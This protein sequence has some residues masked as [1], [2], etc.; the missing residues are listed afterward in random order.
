FTGIKAKFERFS[1]Q[2]LDMYQNMP[3]TYFTS[4]IFN[5]FIDRN[6]ILN[7]MQESLIGELPDV[8]KSVVGKF[9]NI[10]EA[11]GKLKA[12]ISDSEL[13]GKLKGIFSK[14][15]EPI[16]E[17]IIK[18]N[19]EVEP[20]FNEAVKIINNYDPKNFQKVV[21][22]LS[23]FNNN[24]I[25]K[26]HELENALKELIEKYKQNPD[27]QEIQKLLVDKYKETQ[28]YLQLLDNYTKELKN[29]DIKDESLRKF[30]SELENRFNINHS[31]LNNF[32]NSHKIDDLTSN[33]KNISGTDLNKLTK[34]QFE[35][36]KKYDPK[37]VQQFQT[38]NDTFIKIKNELAKKHDDIEKS[39]KEALEKYKQNP[40]DQENILSAS[41]TINS[42]TQFL[43]SLDKYIG[44]LKN[45]TGKDA[46]LD[47][48]INEQIE[49]A[50]KLHSNI[51]KY[52]ETDEFKQLETFIHD[53]YIKPLKSIG[54]TGGITAV[55]GGSVLFAADKYLAYMQDNENYN[56]LQQLTNDLKSSVQNFD[57][58][59]KF[60]DLN[61]IIQLMYKLNVASK[62][63]DAVQLKEL[64][65]LNNTVLNN[66]IPKYLES[67]GLTNIDKTI[68][69][70]L[71]S[72]DPNLQNYI[73]EKSKTIKA[74]LYYLNSYK[75]MFSG[76][77]Q[78]QQELQKYID[79]LNKTQ[80]K[81]NEAQK[82]LIKLQE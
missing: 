22:L 79:Q 38:I 64:Q 66:I 4:K 63:I 72:N 27:D 25:S 56:K 60:D 43:K 29:L 26:R 33:I 34:Q 6:D 30:I 69:A 35:E 13:F 74:L 82:Q 16:H 52:R 10:P 75:G 2:D 71:N 67:N 36:L 70:K 55:G 47:K 59:A 61:K 19:N 20:Q 17:N 57:K 9:G 31:E 42:A 23:K 78:M 5:E 48:L 24:I 39:L 80:E 8:L 12:K 44:N 41:K 73:Q 58:N 40:N 50:E 81:L 68:M 15:P 11:L 65:N 49:Y 21:E 62:P 28:Q 46:A 32:I 54:I 76:N 51:F 77:T 14:E 53:K 45:L 7:I 37:N 1:V 3:I 18:L